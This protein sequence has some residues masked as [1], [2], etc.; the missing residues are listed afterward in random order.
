MCWRVDIRAR[1]IWC[2]ERGAGGSDENLEH[3]SGL[4]R[5][6]APGALTVAVALLAAEQRPHHS[7]LSPLRGSWLLTLTLLLS[8]EK[9]ALPMTNK[10]MGGHVHVPSVPSRGT[11]SFQTS[12]AVPESENPKMEHDSRV[13]HFLF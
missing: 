8:S 1:E 5:V 12:P 7:G 4:W 6:G 13:Q 3:T 9:K 10:N 11:H 2:V